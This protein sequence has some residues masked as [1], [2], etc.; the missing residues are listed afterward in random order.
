MFSINCA[1][2]GEIQVLSDW[3]LSNGKVADKSALA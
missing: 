3:I 2:I 1:A